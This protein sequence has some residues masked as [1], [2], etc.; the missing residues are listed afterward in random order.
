MHTL[1]TP[2]PGFPLISSLFTH[3]LIFRQQIFLAVYLEKIPLLAGNS[4]AAG[5]EMTR[6]LVNQD[7][8]P[9]SQQ[10]QQQFPQHL[11]FKHT[12]RL[13]FPQCD[14]PSFTTTHN[15]II[16][17][18]ASFSQHLFPLLRNSNQ[19][20]FRISLTVFTYVPNK[21]TSSLPTPF[22]SLLP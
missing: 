12:L 1:Y 13:L 5:Q 7:P 6:I 15:I 8:L 3:L 10:S 9:R 16:V 21:S 19:Q 11:V 20:S 14:R 4:A 17:S 22:Q 18:S 2:K